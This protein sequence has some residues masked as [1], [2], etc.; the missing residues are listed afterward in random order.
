MDFTVIQ[1]DAAL[2]TAQGYQANQVQLDAKQRVEDAKD[3][4]DIYHGDVESL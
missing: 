2:L 4:V 3:A 1:A